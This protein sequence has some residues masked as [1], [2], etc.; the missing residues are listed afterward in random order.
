MHF[1]YL[2]YFG[3]LFHQIMLGLYLTWC[4][5]HICNAIRSLKPVE[6]ISA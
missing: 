4:S 1:D 3:I 6:S 2:V 5:N